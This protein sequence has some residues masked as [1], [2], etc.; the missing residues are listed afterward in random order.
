MA[1]LANS[2]KHILIASCTLDSPNWEPVA[3][4][5]EGRGYKTIVYEADKV[6][7]G[8]VP[9]TVTVS[10]EQGIEV[11]YDGEQFCLDA[12]RAAWYRR[13]A[14]IS[15]ANEDTAAQLGIDIERRTIQSALWG[16][17]SER[18]W[19]NAP[20]NIRKADKKISQLILAQRLGFSVPTTIATNHWEPI[21]EGLPSAIICKAS[22]SLFYDGEG[23]KSLYTT[24]FD[25]S[26]GTLP[27]DRNPFPGIWQPCLDKAREW[28]ITVVG[29]DTFDAAI[30]TDEEAKDDWR[31]HQLS[32]SKVKFSKEKFPDDLKEKCVKYLG[33]LG[34]RFGAFDFI[35]KPEGEV[36][37]L[38]CNPNG[39]YMWLEHTL[40]LPIS[41]AVARE[42]SQ[43]AEQ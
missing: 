19:L 18:S 11:S 27:L 1:S 36:V 25:N 28:R 5:L 14:F 15:N 2:E 32:P 13:T 9:F 39:Q 29:D 42:L 8:E 22:Y 43:I 20:D 17:I 34:L 10:G 12:I 30:Y 31:K 4:K 41:E 38:E 40:E 33:E 24:P 16:E 37:F 6:A 26:A 7:L 23:F 21:L 35:E 3:S